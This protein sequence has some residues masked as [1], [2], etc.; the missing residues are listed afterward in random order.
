MDPDVTLSSSLGLDDTLPLGGR[1]DHSDLDGSDSSMA[2]RHQQG[3]EFHV[4]FVDMGH[5]LQHKPK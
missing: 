3:H 1:N 5:R 4:A 2:L